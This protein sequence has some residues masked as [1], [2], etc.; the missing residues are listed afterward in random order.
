M[1]TKT[2]PLKEPL[3]FDRDCP[4]GFSSTVDTS[5]WQHLND[6]RSA[7][8]EK[9]IAEKE[10]TEIYMDKKS[11]LDDLVNDEQTAAKQMEEMREKI[12]TIETYLEDLL[13]NIQIIVSLR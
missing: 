3:D 6:L 2:I 4:D 5:I 7:R 11:K 12:K 10:L 8:I 1:G 13:K 9:E